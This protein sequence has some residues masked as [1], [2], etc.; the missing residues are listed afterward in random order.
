M[1]DRRDILQL[2][3]RKALSRRLLSMHRRRSWRGPI[4]W[5]QDRRQRDLA[6]LTSQLIAIVRCNAPLASGLER[7]IEDAPSFKLAQVMITLADDLRAGFGLS[8]ALALCPRFF[9]AW[10]VDL[11]RV[12]EETGS[13][14][15]ALAAAGDQLG[16]AR[17]F[18]RSILGW[19]WY[20]GAV[21][22]IQASIAIFL[23]VYALPEFL[24]VLKEFGAQ[25][26]PLTR[27]LLPLNP[28]VTPLRA[29]AITLLCAGLILLKIMRRL[30]ADES[31][32][33]PW[34]LTPL[35]AP[36]PIVG[37]L[38]VKG[39]LAG[40]CA[41]IEH[42]ARA[43]VPI[44]DMLYD[45][46]ELR[47]SVNLTRAFKRA[48][49]RVQ[50]GQTLGDA[51]RCER[52]FPSLFVTILSLGESSGRLDDAA[53]Q[54]RNM[55]E[56]QVMTGIRQTIDIAG[57][58]GVAGLGAATFVIYAGIFSAIIALTYALVAAL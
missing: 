40:A 18:R 5:K 36:L 46:S 30:V 49:L 3:L 41:A 34:L 42:L 20:V 7:A 28:L 24:E 32:R 8:H 26:P 38:F 10:Y 44:D 4:Y 13:L 53:H 47:L 27:L 29:Q 16:T 43:N 19:V 21:F 25:P 58:I 51:L 22:C 11:V 9:P 6:L 37:P 54:L 17:R 48:A 50:Q 14:E 39:Q 1:S 15:R 45:C 56:Q 57:P 55:Y 31:V 35:L 12:G 33:L 52:V 23:C 2:D